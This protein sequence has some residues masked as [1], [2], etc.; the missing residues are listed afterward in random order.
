VEEIPWDPSHLIPEFLHEKH[1]AIVEAARKL[2]Y[3]RGTV[4]RVL[5]DG[6]AEDSIEVLVENLV[7]TGWGRD[8][9]NY[10]EAVHKEREILRKQAE[11]ERMEALSEASS[12]GVSKET[13]ATSTTRRSRRGSQNDIQVQDLGENEYKVSGRRASTNSLRKGSLNDIEEVGED[14]PRGSSNL[15]G[16][17][18]PSSTF[19]DRSGHPT[20]ETVGSYDSGGS[21][22]RQASLGRAQRGTKDTNVT[23]RSSLKG[24]KES[25][26]SSQT[27]KELAICLPGEI[28]R[29]MC[30]IC[31]ER[32]I[33]VELQP[34]G[35]RVAC[36][37]CISK[38]GSLCPLC[39][40]FV[41]NRRML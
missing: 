19:Y 38:S 17:R 3:H 28:G 5:N 7:H 37:D 30:T 23:L 4:E 27:S 12:R 21:G 32:P 34:C 25:L 10:R 29:E 15:S 36:E 9:P 8:L 13:S 22:S 18:S 26:R 20:K 40:T 16:S 24:T 35:H 31:L 11:R 33:D 2:G 39:R 6:V 1:T 14:S 41:T